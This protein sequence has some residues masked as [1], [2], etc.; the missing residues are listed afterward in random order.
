MTDIVKRIEQYALDGECLADDEEF[1]QWQGKVAAFLEAAID[2]ETSETFLGHAEYFDEEGG[3][4]GAG[5]LDGLAAKMHRPDAEPP[6]Q[7]STRKATPKKHDTTKVFVV[8][9]HDAKAKETTARFL[10]RLNVRPIILHEQP[11]GGGTIIEKFERHSDVEFAVILLTPDDIGSAIKSKN[12]K[13]RARQN[14][15]F[16]F[17][18]FIG[19]LGRRNVCALYH[20]GVELPSDYEGVVYIRMDEEGAWRTKV[21][22]ELVQAGIAIELDGL[23]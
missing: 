11:S 17:G 20:D 23:L 19:K 13:P 5:F 1:A 22:Q 3:H 6:K 7:A 2:E 16:E 18:Y 14:V 15:I 9:G 12:R 10:E 8:H 4:K 21:A